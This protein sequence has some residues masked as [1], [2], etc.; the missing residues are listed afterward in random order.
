MDVPAFALTGWTPV[1]LSLAHGELAIDWG[2]L[3]GVRFSEPFLHQTIERWAADDPAPLMRTGRA[4]LEAL[5][6]EPSLDP[7]LII[8]HVSRCGS[9]LLSRLLGELPGVL[10]VSEPGPVNSLLLANEFATPAALRL[11]VRAL[12]RKRFGDERH[13][14]LKL[15]SWNVTRATLVRATF[16]AAK[17]V[18]LQRAPE[19]VVASILADPPGWM[20]LRRDPAAVRALFGIEAAA[21]NDDGAF[22]INAIAALLRAAQRLAPDLVL[23]HADLPA[24]AWERAAPLLGLAPGAGDLARMARTA[25]FAAKDAVPRPFTATLPGV[26]RLPAELGAKVAEVLTPLYA[27]LA[28]PEPPLP[29]GRDLRLTARL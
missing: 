5:D 21:D 11:L 24:A 15:S 26:R 13:Y 6:G 19:A 16:P 2:D 28:R 3:R 29:F 12:G 25:C 10:A 8:F 18:W 27:A 20:K 14:V 7:A 22:C 9:T 23:D 4:A 1:A 17:F